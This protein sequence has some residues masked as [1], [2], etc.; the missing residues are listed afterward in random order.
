MRLCAISP[1]LLPQSV[2]V[3][4]PTPCPLPT[5]HSHFPVPSH[6]PIHC[7]YPPAAVLPLLV[8]WRGFWLVGGCCLRGFVAEICLLL[9]LVMVGGENLPTR[10]KHSHHSIS[11]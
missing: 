6:T 3:S 2:V 5:A 8:V 1:P 10:C 11:S 9:L 4:L 7:L